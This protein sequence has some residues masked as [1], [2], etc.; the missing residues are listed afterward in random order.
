MSNHEEFSDRSGRVCVIGAGSSGLAAA[1]N[2]REL[3]FEVEILE[4]CPDL[5]G[6]WNYESP[7]ARVYRSTHTISSKPGT[8]YPDYPM[9][10]SY[11]DYPHHEEVLAYLRGYAENFGLTPIIEYETEVARVEP[12]DVAGPTGEPCW[13]VRLASGERRRYGAMV[14]ANGHNN[15]P[16]VPRYPGRFEGESMHSAEYKV[17]EI[18][19]GKRVLVVGGGNSGCDIVVEAAHRATATFHSTRRGYHYV[20][21][22]LW[23]MPSDQVAD[24]MHLLRI[25]MRV[26]RVVGDISLRLFRG[27]QR[28]LGLPEPDH[29]LFETHPI[30]N[31]LLPY[32]VQHGAIAPKPDIERLDG[33]HVH[34]T[35]GTSEIIDLLIWATGYEITF[36][37]LDE[38]HVSAV[39]GMPRLYKHVFH[40]ES[41]NLFVVGLVQPDSGQFGIVHWQCRAAALYLRSAWDGGPANPWLKTRKRDPVEDLGG[42]IRYQKTYRHHLEVEH[43]SYTRGLRKL[44]RRLEG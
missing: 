4:A 26:Q 33:R 11:P 24:L 1:R 10:A 42:G 20:P 32:F 5:G 28:D 40:P 13:D 9:P 35:D 34:F 23:G 29:R 31:T 17:S 2:F 41:D 16:M 22:Y 12:S 6:N 25:P 15:V 38:E 27:R 43:A 18:L 14:I 7:A 44:V 19:L 30:V 36:P 3:G 21:K 37:F 39:D 8:E